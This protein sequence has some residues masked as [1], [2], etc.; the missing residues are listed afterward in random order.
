MATRVNPDYSWSP[1]WR[2]L[3]FKDWCPAPAATD[4][5]SKA[6][7][8]KPTKQRWDIVYTSAL[9]FLRILSIYW[10]GSHLFA[11]FSVFT[12]SSASLQEPV[13]RGYGFRDSDL[14]NPLNRPVRGCR[15]FHP[16][17]SRNWLDTM[18]PRDKDKPTHRGTSTGFETSP[19]HLLHHVRHYLLVSLLL[20]PHHDS[21]TLLWC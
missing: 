15:A 14:G 9:E 20:C 11:R 10:V 2:L 6:P 8:L 17:Y 16:E 3:H 1:S 13:A 19:Y 7:N 12:L 21:L 4:R 5:R 18:P